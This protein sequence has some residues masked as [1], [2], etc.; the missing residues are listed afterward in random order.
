[1]LVSSDFDCPFMLSAGRLGRPKDAFDKLDTLRRH[2]ARRALEAARL[3][4]LGAARATMAQITAAIHAAPSHL[5]P[6]LYPLAMQAA[7]TLEAIEA[8][9]ASLYAAIDAERGAAC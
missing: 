6:R 9:R 2:N 3:P 4:D 8:R 1:M 5:A 7:V